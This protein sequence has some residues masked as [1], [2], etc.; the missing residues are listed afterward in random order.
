MNYTNI[1]T[2]NVCVITWIIPLHITFL[3]LHTL[4]NIKKFVTVPEEIIHFFILTQSFSLLH[5]TVGA[6]FI[7]EGENYIFL[8]LL[9]YF[10]G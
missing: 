2:Q 1:T 8:F 4:T 5:I 3:H 7:K 9:I 6:I 10:V